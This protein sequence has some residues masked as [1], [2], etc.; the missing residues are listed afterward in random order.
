MISTFQQVDK[1]IKNL[2]GQI[3][4]LKNATSSSD[5]QVLTDQDTVDWDVSLGNFA[6]VTIA[7]NRILTLSNTTN[8]STGLLK[9]VQDGSG[10]RSLLLPGNS[11]TSYMLSTGSGE[12]DIL[13]FINIDGSIFWSFEN[14]GTVPDSGGGGSD[15]DADAEAF[16]TATGIANDATV[17]F[18]ATPQQIT[19]EEIWT[20][21]NDFV[22]GAKL[23]NYYSKLV[24]LYPFLG[25]TAS[26]HKWN[27]KDPQDQ[28]AS[29]R[30]TFP[31]SAT[32]TGTG[33]DFNGVNQ[34]GE[35]F[36]SA[37]S[38]NFT[39]FPSVGAS[40]YL[41]ELLGGDVYVGIG[42]NTSFAP[43][44]CD[45]DN[46]AYVQIGG[47]SPAGVTVTGGDK[48]ALWTVQRKDASTVECYNN[49]ALKTTESTT[50]DNSSATTIKLNRQWSAGNVKAVGCSF[51][52]LHQA[53]SSTEVGNLNTDVVALQTA[54][55]RNVTP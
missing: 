7:G 55:H 22:V 47:G 31:N 43:Y 49:G 37:N 42:S 4:A 50:A 21:Y 15:F 54:L 19:G 2:R 53:L 3:F 28:D 48:K 45:T 12:M 11:P 40:Y 38:T 13:G 8:N 26:T 39:G 30:M 6:E 41:Q 17:L 29:F 32:H 33:I 46:K 52:V 20:A 34:Y 44:H 27:A 18:S 10:A 1:Q 25:G 35:T 5:F 24:V 16:L 36:M 9:V 23:N 14:Y 51:F